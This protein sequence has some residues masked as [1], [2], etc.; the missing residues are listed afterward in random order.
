MDQILFLV[1]SRQ[2]A[3]VVA[4]D[5]INPALCQTGLLEVLEVAVVTLHLAL[6]VVV[7]AQEDKVITAVLDLVATV[8]LV[9]VV[10]E[11]LLLAQITRLQPRGALAVRVLPIHIVEVA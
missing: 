2:Q 5:K 4:A 1:V 11:L 10:A 6:A 8:G 3:A 9:A 7:L